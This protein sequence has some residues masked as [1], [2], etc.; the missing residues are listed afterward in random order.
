MGGGHGRNIGLVVAAIALMAATSASAG[1]F[2]FER[3]EAKIRAE[4]AYIIKT[5]CQ[6]ARKSPAET[7]ECIKDVNRSLAGALK[8]LRRH[9][10][11]E[12]EHDTKH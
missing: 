11:V 4:S 10:G 2:E 3:D 6:A 1:L 8:G 7:R 12:Q 9:H 5:E